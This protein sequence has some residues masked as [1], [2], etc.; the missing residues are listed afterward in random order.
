MD[1]GKSYQNG[2]TGIQHAHSENGIFYFDA[3]ASIQPPNGPS[4]QKIHPEETEEPVLSVSPLFIHMEEELLGAIK[5]MDEL[6][7]GE[8]VNKDMDEEFLSVSKDMDQEF[9]GA[10]ALSTTMESLLD[11]DKF[12]Q[13][14]TFE[15]FEQKTRNDISP[16]K[17]K[18]SPSKAK[19]KSSPKHETYI[20][21]CCSKEPVDEVKLSK[22]GGCRKAWYC[23]ESCQ[24]TDWQ[25]HGSYCMKMQ[26]KL[27]KKKQA[28]EKKS[29]EI[30]A[31]QSKYL[32]K[33][34]R[35]SFV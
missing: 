3:D 17:E 10:M 24:S 21:W 33:K 4:K 30:D 25:D 16:E 32:L 35:T 29:Q 5:D 13:V 8:T 9:L 7:L 23:S 11:L 14:L 22:C 19:S 26:E 20:C 1:D 12:N 27:T 34:C 15:E 18:K 28:K 2:A 31:F 6:L